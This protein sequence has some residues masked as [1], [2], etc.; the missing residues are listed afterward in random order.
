MKQ[1]LHLQLSGGEDITVEV[2]VADRKEYLDNLEF[3]I[4]TGHILKFGD[5]NVCGGH[6][7]AWQLD[8]EPTTTTQEPE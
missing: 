5:L 2:C 1:K 7:V 6:V 3:E 8:Q 4:K